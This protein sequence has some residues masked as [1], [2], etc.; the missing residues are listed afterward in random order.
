MK[1]LKF[2]YTPLNVG[3]CYTDVETIAVPGNFKRHRIITLF[4]TGESNA[5]MFRI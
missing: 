1:L 3:F 5:S 4:L 2:E